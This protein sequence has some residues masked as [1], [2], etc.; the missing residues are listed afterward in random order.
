M[1]NYL[2]VML[3]KGFV[4]LPKQDVKLELNNSISE[5][6]IELS[7]KHHNGDLLVVCPKNSLEETPEIND[8][9]VVGVVAHLKSS[10]ELPNG[11]IR[12]VISG[13]K[14]VDV[15]KYNNFDDD[16]DI[17]MADVS[18]VNPPEEDLVSETAIKRKLIELLKKYINDNPSLS[19]S[20]LSAIKNNDDLG[21]ITDII[22]AFLP[23]SLDKKILYMEEVSP[24]KRA[25]ALIYDISIELEILKLDTKLDE[26][27]QEDLERNQ[28]EF[29]LK[30]KLKEIKKELGEENDKEEIINNYE[31]RI[32][33][34]NT[35]EKTKEKLLRELHKYANM[36]EN[37]PES[38][39]IINYLDTVIN[40]PWNKSKKDNYNTTLVRKNLDKTHYGLDNV[41]NRIIEYITIKKR[42][43][44]FKSPILCLVGAPGVG[45][46]SIAISIAE[47]LNKEFY[48][49]SVGGLT[50][51]SELVGHRRTYLGSNPGKIIQAISK[52]GV[53]NPLILIDE[54]DKM[55]KDFRGDP[56]S[57]LLEILDTS[58]NQY[59]IDNYIEEP[60]D[61]SN[62]LFILTANDIDNIPVA[63]RDRLE[64]L[65]I[66]SYSDFEKITMAKK[67][68]LPKI[69]DSHIVKNDDIKFKD[70]LLLFI[71]NNYTKESGVRELSR[72]LESLVRKIIT[73]ESNNNIKLPI[74]LD[75][76]LV[77]KYLGN[78]LFGTE[79]LSK[80][81]TPGLVNALACTNLGGSILPIE[82]CMY[83]G[84][85][86]IITT[87]LL[88]QSTTE[89]ISVAISYIRSHNDLYKI[90][91]YYFNTKDIHLHALNAAIKKDGPS[92]GITITTC[93]L[94]LILNKTIPKNIAMTGEISLRGDILQIGGLKEK[95]LAAFNNKI[96]K[97]Y[98]PLSNEKDLEDIP[99]K[100]LSKLKIIKVSNYEEIFNDLFK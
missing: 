6:I 35:N 13:T 10:I 19:N 27:L 14:R 61:L 77:I 78:P 8:L 55:G 48:K 43:P 93:I 57:A 15:N 91:D 60:F 37:Y 71:I 4:I 75:E 58:Q 24:M 32:N 26:V 40:L 21:I 74:N 70:E 97:I 25:N 7:K 17:L 16:E 2:P 90:S 42:N 66:S 62:V 92:A 100:I 46:T 11:N 80:T 23:F 64:I 86:N 49:I 51:P 65:E 72:I 50:D 87:G 36:N 88:G 79:E 3:L 29:I 33:K 53:K 99:E 85:G 39:I 59:F 12:I 30:S 20:V 95:I 96:T 63:L 94:S 9:P 98:I 83:E 1:N 41:K 67:Y 31:E 81:L 18:V 52:C 22:T 89:S 73:D 38:S 28:K 69:F 84:K 44:E 56:T 68:I 34:I 76:K 45:K 5:K 54:V 82:C 47:S